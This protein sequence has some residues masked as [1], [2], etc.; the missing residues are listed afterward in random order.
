RRT[1]FAVHFPLIDYFSWNSPTTARNELAASM[2]SI[3]ALPG[4]PA[5]SATRVRKVTAII[6]NWNGAHLLGA[7]LGSIEARLSAVPLEI[8]LVDH[9]S[10]DDSLAIV[11]RYS[12]SLDVRV[13]A[14]GENFSFSNS[15]NLAAQRAS[16]EFLLFLNNDIVFAEDSVS[17]LS[18]TLA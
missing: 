7:L 1:T 4:P 3:A 5:A 15:N 16:G 2:S 13:I 18:A 10:T 11:E 14:R 12:H 8:I 9:G 17:R 6:L